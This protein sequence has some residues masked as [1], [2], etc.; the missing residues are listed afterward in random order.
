[1]ARKRRVKVS[2][3]REQMK[4]EATVLLEPGEQ[5]HVDPSNGGVTIYWIGGGGEVCSS[6][7]EAHELARE[8][9]R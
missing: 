2:I 8:T 6:R 9:S 5:L 1:M 4:L 7:K 3:E